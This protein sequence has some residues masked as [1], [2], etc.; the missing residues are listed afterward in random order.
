MSF[1][2][3]M[4]EERID[5]WRQRVPSRL[6]RRDPFEG[7]GFDERPATRL[8]FRDPSPPPERPHT[9]LSFLRAATPLFG[10]SSTP[11][12]QNASSTMGRRTEGKRKTLLNLL[13]RKRKRRE[14]EV[15]VPRE[16]VRLNFLFVGSKEAGQTSLLFR[17]R[18]GYFPD[19]NGF[20]RPLYETYVND[21]IYH[22]QPDTSG[23]PDLN[24]VEKLTYIEWDAVFLC[25]DIS[26]K[27]SMYTIIQWQWHH[28]SNQGFAKSQTFEP[29]LYLVGL[30]KDLRDQCFLED[31]QS[32]S[33]NSSSGLLAYPTCCVC[34]SEAMWQA[35]RIG[36][37]RYVECSAAT[38][39]GMKEVVDD[40]ARE[41][42]RRVV[43]G[44]CSEDEPIAAKKR[45]RFF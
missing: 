17:S 2:S 20:S 30:K 5:S 12:D 36:A 33:S 19:S 35:Q 38:G 1:L 18:Y 22:G 15:E 21:R 31:H 43:G 27:I 25:F 6:E 3:M 28:A 23:V 42:M 29:F 13:S 41:A 10:R 11:S 9:R 4:P 40:S 39:E 26:D 37:H 7:D 24:T 32:S 45:R 14:Q 44:D 16:P 34:P 8:T